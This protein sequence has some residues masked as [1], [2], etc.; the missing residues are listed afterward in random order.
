VTNQETSIR[1]NTQR[2]DVKVL[3]PRETGAA[4]LGMGNGDEGSESES[5]G[6]SEGEPEEIDPARGENPARDEVA[7]S[8]EEEEEEAVREEVPV[9]RPKN[10]S[11]PTPEE[12]ERHCAM[13]H[14]PYRPWCSVCVQA[15]AREDGHYKKSKESQETGLPT[16]SMDYADVGE[17][18]GVRKLLIGREQGTKACFSHLVRCKGL[19]DEK[20]VGKVIKSIAKM[21]HTKIKVK[22]DGE[23]SIV[24]LQEKIIEER[25]QETIPE[26]PPAYDPQSNGVAERAVQEVKAQMRALALGLGARLQTRIDNRWSIMEWIVQHAPDT[27]NR[28]LIGADGRTAHYRVHHRNFTAKVFEIG[29][30]VLAKPKRHHKRVKHS[31]LSARWHE[32]TW[33]G[34]TERSNEHIVVLAKGG[35]SDKS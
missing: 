8:S 24:Q 1:P 19:G 33:V 13:G 31:T 22:T 29:E 12:K 7:E 4:L 28:F 20:I 2:S 15:R 9:K 6:E 30:Q 23:P 5:E 3:R 25:K 18:E 17:K 21:G 10:P 14:L 27:V 32:A 11:D 34:F 16:V 26:N 35:A